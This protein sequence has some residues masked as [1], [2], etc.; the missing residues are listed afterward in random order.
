MPISV[1]RLW[2]TQYSIAW[3]TTATGSSSSPGRLVA[4]VVGVA[5]H[6]ASAR[7]STGNEATEMTVG[8]GRSESDHLIV[9]IRPLSISS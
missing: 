7:G 8:V 9:G 1:S 5:E 6:A 4:K 2:R 3:F